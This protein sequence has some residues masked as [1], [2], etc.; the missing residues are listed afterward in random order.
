MDILKE[1]YII[2][3]IIPTTSKKETG[4]LVQI[5]ALKLHGL[6]LLERFDYRLN[7]AKIQIPDLVQLTSYDKEN[8]IYLESTEQLLKT[9]SIWSCGLPLLILDNDYTKSY[10]KDLPNLKQSICPFLKTEY[11]ENIIETLIQKYQL[12]PSNYIVDLLYESILKEN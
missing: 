5:S 3:E 1:K 4:D 10:L 8:F 6:Q 2:I 7:P 11:Q 12:E 9:F